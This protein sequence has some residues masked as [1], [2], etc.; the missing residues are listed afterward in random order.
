MRITICTLAFALIATTTCSAAT[1]KKLVITCLDQQESSFDD[2]FLEIKDDNGNLVQF[3]NSD[4]KGMTRQNA[5]NM[6]RGNELILNSTTRSKLTFS[7]NLTVKIMEKD[8][9]TNS[10]P[11]DPLGTVTILP[12]QKETEELE[13][14]IQ[15]RKYKYKIHWETSP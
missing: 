12:N 4:Q 11:D 5:V 9:G 2:I 14:R 1:V 6:I 8:L 3:T 10:N 13:G 7:K 15:L